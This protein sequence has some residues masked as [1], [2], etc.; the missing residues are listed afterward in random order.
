MVLRK[1][2]LRDARPEDK[3]SVIA[4]CSRTWRDYGDFIPRVWDRWIAEKTGRLIVAE[5]EGQPVGIAKITDFTHG[6]IWLEGLR[7]DPRWRK[8]GVATAI[9]A[10]ILNTIKKLKPRSVRYC[11]AASNKI[12]RR[13]GNKSGFVIAARFRYYWRRSRSGSI[14][15]EY[16]SAND[17]DLILEFVKSSRFCRLSNGLIS[18]GW[19][20]REVKEGLIKKYIDQR[21]VVVVY[22]NG[23]VSGVGIYP[24]EVN[25]QTL[26]LGFVDGRSENTILRLSRNC[27]RLA[28]DL[29]LKYCSASVPTRHF[30]RLLEKRGYHRSSSVSQVVMELRYSKYSWL[31]VSREKP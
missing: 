20:F 4:F 27:P 10:E 16:A 31:D 30:S 11:T 28:H 1:F 24:D 25:E 26:T 15:G 18:E 21:R 3:E 7:V 17:L 2:L 12:S 6:E 14:F 22:K 13:I 8:K 19:I 5:A 23:E 29:G 9:T